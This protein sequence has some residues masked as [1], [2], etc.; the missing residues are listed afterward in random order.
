MAPL[1]LINGI[2]LRRPLRLRSRRRFEHRGDGDDAQAA[3]PWYPSCGQLVLVQRELEFRLVAVSELRGTSCRGL[4]GVVPRRFF[5][6]MPNT[7]QER[8]RGNTARCPD[9]GL[10]LWIGARVASLRC[11]SGCCRS[12]WSCPS[13]AS[14]AGRPR[15]LIVNSSERPAL[16]DAALR[17]TAALGNGRFSHEAYCSIFAIPLTASS[18]QAAWSVARAWSWWSFGRWTTT[19]GIL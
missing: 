6:L 5:A 11:P 12:D 17:D 7:K 19:L 8:E 3:P 16:R 1:S 10:G 15:R 4:R 9:S 13:N 14:D 2:E 18:L